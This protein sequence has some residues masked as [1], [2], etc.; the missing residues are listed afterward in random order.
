VIADMLRSSLLIVGVLFV[1]HGVSD[2]SSWFV[3]FG[4]LLL[5]AY[6]GW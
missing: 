6:S 2:P 3:V 5:G 1:A 4:G